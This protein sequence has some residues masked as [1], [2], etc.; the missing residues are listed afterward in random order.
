MQGW[1]CDYCGE[2]GEVPDG[3]LVEHVQCPTCGEPVLPWPD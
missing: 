3:E 2:R 1:I